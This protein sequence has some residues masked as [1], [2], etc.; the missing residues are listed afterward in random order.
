MAF[1]TLFTRYGRPSEEAAINIS[2]FLRKPEALVKP[3]DIGL[4]DSIAARIIAQCQGVIE[5]LQSYRQALAARYG[6]L[7]TM[8]YN[9]VLSIERRKEYTGKVRYF[10][11]LTRQYADESKVELSCESFPGKERHK[12]FERFNELKKARPGILTTTDT[13]KSAWER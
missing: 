9:D 6:E 8:P 3:A 2:G 1:E 12:A 5:A 11:R 4:Y 10:V 7:E 13:E